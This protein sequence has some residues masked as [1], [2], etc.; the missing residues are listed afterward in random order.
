M[1]VGRWASQ[2]VPAEG[3]GGH[4][5]A[6]GHVWVC[7]LAPY[8]FGGELIGSAGVLRAGRD[9]EPTALG[10]AVPRG[11]V[12]GWETGLPKHPGFLVRAT[13]RRRGNRSGKRPP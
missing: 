11:S 12:P 5:G 2:A 1:G 7:V 4:A 8:S 10:C 9:S 3:P 13:L 6:A